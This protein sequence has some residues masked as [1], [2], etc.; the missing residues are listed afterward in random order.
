MH[1][2]DRRAHQV[3]DGR[4]YV[5]HEGEL[6]AE[7]ALVGV[8]NA[9]GP[10]HDEGNVHASLVG[11]LLVPPERR[12]A[13]LGPPPRVVAVAPRTSDVV[14]PFHSVVWVLQDAVEVLHLMED[15]VGSSLLGSSVISQDQQ[16]GVVEA[17]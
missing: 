8:S 1:F 10:V 16:D 11:V 13:G 6:V 17:S 2:G 9:S 3:V 12:V 14:Q 15:P 5:G 7:S 4:G